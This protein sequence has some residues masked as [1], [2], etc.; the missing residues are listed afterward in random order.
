M[1]ACY[2]NV[3]DHHPCVR[4][5]VL[6]I[7]PFSLSCVHNRACKK[8]YTNAWAATDR[9]AYV[10]TRWHELCPITYSQ[11]HPSSN[12]IFIIHHLWWSAVV[13]D[14]GC[15]SLFPEYPYFTNKWHNQIQIVLVFFVE[16]EYNECHTYLQW[17]SDIFL[18]INYCRSR[19][20]RGCWGT[21]VDI[22]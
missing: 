21:L 1:Y 16:I 4:E 5:Y 9:Q 2:C 10:K 6:H 17:W 19:W 20:Y 15:H 11:D 22:R 8:H 13:V 12:R 14:H 7:T 18:F 3:L